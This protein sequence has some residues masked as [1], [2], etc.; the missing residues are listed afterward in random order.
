MASEINLLKKGCLIISS[1]ISLLVFS[2]CNFLQ[3]KLLLGVEKILQTAC[4]CLYIFE[5]SFKHGSQNRIFTSSGTTL[6]N[7]NPTSLAFIFFP[8]RGKISFLFQLSNDCSSRCGRTDA[9]SLFK[10]FLCS[11]FS[12][13]VCIFSIAAISVPSVKYA[14]GFGHILL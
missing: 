6:S 1:A 9:V 12:T 2:F 13:M 3:N 4:S 7:A 5:F 10:K 14:G 8:F 11:G